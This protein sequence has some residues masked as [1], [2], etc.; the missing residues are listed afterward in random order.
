L[1]LFKNKDELSSF[2]HRSYS[3]IKSKYEKLLLKYKKIKNI[4]KNKFLVKKKFKKKKKIKI[5]QKLINNIKKTK[6]KKIFIT[7]RRK[8]KKLHM[9]IIKAKNFKKL[10]KRIS[11][12]HSLSKF[13]KNFKFYELYRPLRYLF[14]YNTKFKKLKSYYFR[15][16]KIENKI[17]TFLFYDRF[18]KKIN[19]TFNKYVEKIESIKKGLGFRFIYS[20]FTFKRFTNKK[21]ITRKIK[22]RLLNSKKKKIF[23]KLKLTP[24]FKKVSNRGLR[25]VFKI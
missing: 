13:I 19:N 4:K 10:L 5:R 6:K 21:N 7:K 3:K 25:R 11:A 20:I 8:R 14:P 9:K 12:K 24:L 22:Q 17:N 15:F 16:K 18:K 2:I 23:N 1:F